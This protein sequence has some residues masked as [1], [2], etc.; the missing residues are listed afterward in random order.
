MNNSEATKENLYVITNHKFPSDSYGE[1]D[2]LGNWPMLYILENGDKVYIG[3]ST[4]VAER[5]K[6]HYNNKEKREFNKVHFIYSG[7][8]NQSVTFDYESKLIQFVSADGK[9]TITNKND[10]I[11]NKN[12][13]SKPEYDET[14]EALWNKLRS[15][16]LAEH[17]LEYIKN[18]EFYKYSPF[19]ELNKDQKILADDIIREIREGKELPIVVEGRPGTG[20]TIVAVYLMKYL[21]DYEDEKTHR[22][23]FREKKMGLIIPQTSLRSTLKSLF[24]KIEGLAA[25][26][27]IGASEAV[28]AGEWDIL[29]VDEAQKLQVR[30]S[31]VGYQAYDN[32]NKK[33]GLPSDATELDWIL[34]I[35]KTPVFFFD[36]D[37]LSGP[38]GTTIEVFQN[39]V[40]MELSRRRRMTAYLTHFLRMQMRVKGGEEYINYVN[41]ILHNVDV[42]RK[43]FDDYDFK[44]FTH[45][46]DF[47]KELYVKEKDME[48]CRM[49]AGYAW[50]WK[51][52]NDKTAYDIEIEGVKKRWNHCLNNWINSDGALDEVGCIHTS[53]GYD[54]NYAFV[55]LGNDIKYDDEKGRIYVDRSN[56]FDK[57]G[58]QSASDEEL[59]LYIK[60]IYYVLMTRGI[61]GTYLYVCDEKLRNYFMK[62][63]EEF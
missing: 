25:K 60:N 47:N 49:L 53:A 38:S 8:F 57:R 37:Q 9:Y 39:K 40:K 26:D 13:F 22:F 32:N 6:Q 51:T 61:R 21:R 19:K 33:L 36:P 43:T 18:S 56:Y 29:F 1:D 44:I 30:R 14:F 59:D 20:K 23:P 16:N 55:I 46:A 28:K 4:N 52:K 35:S 54:L 3:E 27:V 41:D 17:T 15:Y 34:K 24:K 5:M 42:P 45:F 31:I 12:Y 10:G 2:Y 50:E 58:K 48:L 7:R 62:Y 11:A 63:V